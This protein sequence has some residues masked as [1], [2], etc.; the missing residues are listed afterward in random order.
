MSRHPTVDPPEP[1]SLPT[2]GHH[3]TP[4]PPNTQPWP[5]TTATPATSRSTGPHASTAPTDSSAVRTAAA[6]KPHSA[7]NRTHTH[8]A[9]KC[10]EAVGDNPPAIQKPPQPTGSHPL[11][12]PSPRSVDGDHYHPLPTFRIPAGW[13]RNEPLCLP[14]RTAVGLQNNTHDR[15]VRL[16]AV[17]PHAP[18]GGPYAAEALVDTDQVDPQRIAHLTALEPGAIQDAVDLLT[19]AAELAEVAHGE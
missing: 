8:S 15:F 3:Q 4:T 5:P 13:Q 10:I 11:S 18:G 17:S 1:N 6:Q 14:D 2:S 12:R 7:H 9:G 19:T 16:W